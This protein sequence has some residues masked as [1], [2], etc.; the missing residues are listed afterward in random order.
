MPVKK[1]VKKTSAAKKP[2]AKKVVSKAT[3][4]KVVSKPVV[5][6]ETKKTNK[7]T[8]TCEKTMRVLI[9]ALLIL[10]LGFGLFNLFKKDL[11]YN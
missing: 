2:V 5:I 3:T 9:F 4:S 6:V 1:T 8:N 10:N 7:G 11:R